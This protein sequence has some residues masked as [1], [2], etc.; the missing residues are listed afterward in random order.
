MKTNGDGSARLGIGWHV[1]QIGD[2]LQAEG[3][4]EHR[5]N[6]FGCVNRTRLQRLEDLAGGHEHGVD[7]EL[8]QSRRTEAG[9]AHVQTIKIFDAVQALLE[10]TAGLGVGIA[11]IERLEIALGIDLVEQ[12]LSATPI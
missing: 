12:L 11:G 2:A 8:A 6:P 5:A 4:V 7:A 1:A 3:L 9:N 10:P